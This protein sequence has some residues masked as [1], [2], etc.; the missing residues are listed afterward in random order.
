MAKEAGLWMD[1]ANVEPHQ[2]ARP[3]R[4]VRQFRVQ[5]VAAITLAPVVWVAFRSKKPM[6]SRH[7]K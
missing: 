5:G 3:G 1:I 2:L 6:A 4:M 7:C